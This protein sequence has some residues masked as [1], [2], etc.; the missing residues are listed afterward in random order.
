MQDL[1]DK[2]LRVIKWLENLKPFN[3]YIPSPPK[4]SKE[5][6]DKYVIPHYIRCGAIPK[7]KLI[8][9]KTYIGHCRNAN[10]AIWDGERFVYKRTKLGYMYN[11]KINHFQDDNG[12]DVFI[13]IKIKE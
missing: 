8:I 1:S 4:V 11:E 12:N 10:E 6:Y 13:P 2:E 7:D 3:D 5:I 9:G